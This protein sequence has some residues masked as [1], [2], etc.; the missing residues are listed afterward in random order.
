MD[1]WSTI[2]LAGLKL[3][4]LVPRRNT[5]SALSLYPGSALC[6]MTLLN[7]WRRGEQHCLAIQHSGP[8]PKF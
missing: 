8:E 3:S 5:P 1:P 7:P 2:S 4:V 6:L